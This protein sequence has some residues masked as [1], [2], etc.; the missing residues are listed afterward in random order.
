MLFVIVPVNPVQWRECSL[1]PKA[2]RH[3]ALG[4]AIISPLIGHLPSLCKYL[5]SMLEK[6]KLSDWWPSEQEAK[7]WKH[8]RL[9]RPALSR[10]TCNGIARGEARRAAT[11]VP[12]EQSSSREGTLHH[13]TSVTTSPSQSVVT[14]CILWFVCP[15]GILDHTHSSRHLLLVQCRSRK[16]GRGTS[17]TYVYRH[18]YICVSMHVYRTL[19]LSAHIYLQAH[20]YM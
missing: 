4:Q 19:L 16:N 6:K 18:T 9:S 1:E 7:C 3:D 11:G 14:S 12:S 8:C 5:S 17:K 2:G 20:A 10:A 13:I 15:S